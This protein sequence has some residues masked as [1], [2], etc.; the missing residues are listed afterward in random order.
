MFDFLQRAFLGTGERPLDEPVA[1]SAV[2]LCFHCNL[3]VTGAAA[4]WVEFEGKRRLVCC[5]GCQAVFN[6]VVAHGMIDLYDERARTD[7]SA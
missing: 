2:P 3:P 4:P 6:V 5:S 7:T 1:I